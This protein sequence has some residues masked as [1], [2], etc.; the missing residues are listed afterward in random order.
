MGNCCSD[1][2]MKD[3]ARLY[4]AY[5]VPTP[6]AFQKKSKQRHSDEIRIIQTP[7]TENN[8]ENNDF[9]YAKPDENLDDLSENSEKENSKP[10]NSPDLIQ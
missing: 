2:C 7:D 10:E 6:T 4:D 8:N 9:D 3:A 1:D 5:T